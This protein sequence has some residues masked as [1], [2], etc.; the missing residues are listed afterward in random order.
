MHNQ[1]VSGVILAGGNSR[2]MGTNKALVKWRGKA[3]FEW[4]FSA[5]SFVCDEIIISSNSDPGLFPGYWL[6]PDLHPGIGPIAGLESGLFHANN[7]LV[8]FASCDTPL[9]SSDLFKYMLDMH[10]DF[11]ISLATHDGIN[12]P[13]IGVYTKSVY[14]AF[15]DAINEGM[16]KP[17]H[18]IR[19]LNWQEINIHDALNFYSVDMFL[20]LNRPEDLK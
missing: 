16:H 7:N 12:E 15:S 10:N 19:S 3:L 9:L 4:V 18:V 1:K 5:M 11:D 14:K 20:N 13:M 8:L 6:V 17:P 2:R